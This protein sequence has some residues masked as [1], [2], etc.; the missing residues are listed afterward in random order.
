[1]PD[2]DPTVITRRIVIHG[3]VQGVGFRWSLMERAGELR[4][5]GWVRNRADGSV[6]ALLSGPAE[7]VDALTAWAHRGPPHARVAR[8]TWQDEPGT[9]D[10]PRPGRFTQ[11]PT[12]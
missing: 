11:K 9:P 1:M 5:E 7:G 12:L 6:E 2:P 8:I 10:Q 4:L 3:R